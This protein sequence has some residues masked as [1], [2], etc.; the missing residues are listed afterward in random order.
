MSG[1]DEEYRPYTI[2]Y[3]GAGAIKTERGWVSSRD[4]GTSGAT[5]GPIPA[6]HYAEN[7]TTTNLASSPGG[8]NLCNTSGHGHR[9]ERSTSS[10]TRASHSGPIVLPGNDKEIKGIKGPDGVSFDLPKNYND[11]SS[12]SNR[13]IALKIGLLHIKK[14]QLHENLHQAATNPE[15][16]SH[17]PREQARFRDENTRQ[18][19]E[20]EA[21]IRAWE[22]VQAN[23][24]KELPK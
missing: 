21:A 14:G 19:S 3:T 23:R 6:F 12:M 22:E 20:I 16:L 15:I 17:E 13:E 4:I 5:S 10:G 8:E 7:T 1:N 18:L 2:P 24:A 9:S 11:L